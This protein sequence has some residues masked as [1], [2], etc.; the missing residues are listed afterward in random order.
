MAILAAWFAALGTSW[1]R[2][3]RWPL[4]LWFA[5]ARV[6]AAEPSAPSNE[7]Q[8]KAVFLFQ[9]AQF[10]EWPASAFPDATMPFV[11]GVVGEDPFGPYLDEL[12]QGEKI[13]S[14]PIVIRRFHEPSE[15]DRCHILFVSRSEAA[16][17]GPILA[18]VDHRSVLTI[19]DVDTFTRAGGIVRFV[20]EA[21]KVRLRIN[22]EAAKAAGLTISSKILRPATIVTAGKD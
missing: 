8:I 6:D 3:W 5:F 19:S 4:L 13:G 10:A 7:Y 16:R 18:H 12:V 22:V 2:R 21:G 15:T 17:L 11:I 1:T 14:R 9:F 20:M